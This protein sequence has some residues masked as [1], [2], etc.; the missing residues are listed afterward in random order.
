VSAINRALPAVRGLAPAR[1]RELVGIVARLVATAELDGDV[2]RRAQW[3]QWGLEGRQP[4][5]E[6]LPFI[7]DSPP[8]V[9]S[10]L[11]VAAAEQAA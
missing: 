6:P 10:A 7:A 2:R 1:Q 3:L 11:A 5:Q 9:P 8:L 4:G